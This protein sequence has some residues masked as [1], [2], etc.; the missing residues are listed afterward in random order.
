MTHPLRVGTFNNKSPVE[1]DRSRTNGGFEC[2]PSNESIFQTNS[3]PMKEFCYSPR[4]HLFVTSVDRHSTREGCRL[5][6][7]VKANTKSALEC[8]I[9][10]EIISAPTYYTAVRA[11]QS[12]VNS[13]RVR[14]ILVGKSE[15]CAYKSTKPHYCPLTNTNAHFQSNAL[16][17]IQS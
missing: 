14:H 8:S 17:Y 7:Y 1:V 13:G 6:F 9:S 16:I 15:P 2:Y 10:T 5:P 12:N 3:M 11:P 4:F